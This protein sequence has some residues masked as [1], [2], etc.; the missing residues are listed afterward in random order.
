MVQGLIS[1]IKQE[2]TYVGVRDKQ[3]ARRLFTQPGEWALFIGEYACTYHS[4]FLEWRD[5][6]GGRALDTRHIEWE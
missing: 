5:Y 4:L 2:M 1:T 6:S 3:Q